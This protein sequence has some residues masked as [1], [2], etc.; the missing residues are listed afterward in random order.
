MENNTEILRIEN[1]TKHYKCQN[2]KMLM[3]IKNLLYNSYDV[4]IQHMDF[5]LYQGEILGITGEGHC[6]KST[7]LKLLSGNIAPTSGRIF[8]EQSLVSPEE[9]KN[10]VSYIS[11]P[12]LVINHSLTLME[13]IIQN[14]DSKD[15]SLIVDKA[16]KLLEAFG[17]KEYEFREL[18]K[19]PCNVKSILVSLIPLISTKW[20]LCIDQPFVYLE[21]SIKD[22][23]FSQLRRLAD[24]GVSIIITASS[25]SELSE[26]CDRVIEIA[27]LH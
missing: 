23:Y 10:L 6:G 27:P 16:E 17:I 4:G 2:E 20:I 12:E 11:I 14:V 5:S 1:L 26:I 8:F 24:S 18:K 15:R 25:K 7:L 3:A 21:S 19:L 13:N 9:L 22:K